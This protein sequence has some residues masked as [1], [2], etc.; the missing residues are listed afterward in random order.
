MA[1]TENTF[2]VLS[3]FFVIMFISFITVRGDRCLKFIRRGFTLI[4]LLVVIA[5]IAMLI[6]L[7]LPAIQQAREAARRSQCVNNLKQ[8]GIAAHNYAAT[9]SVLPTQPPTKPSG[10]ALVQAIPNG[11]LVRLLPYLEQQAVYDQLNMQLVDVPTPTTMPATLRLNTTG[12]NVAINSYTCPSD[13]TQQSTVLSTFAVGSMSTRFT[14]T[15]LLW[16]HR[17][18]PYINANGNLQFLEQC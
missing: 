8:I 9:F 15:N 5:I 2:C 18:A 7:L 11:W 14:S 1:V 10:L 17:I 12:L 16:C 13:A 4:E 3:L 6:A